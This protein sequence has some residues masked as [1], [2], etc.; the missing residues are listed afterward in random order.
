MQCPGRSCA[1]LTAGLGG[2]SHCRFLLLPLGSSLPSRPSQCVSRVVPPGCPFPSPAGTPLHAVCAFRGLGP[3]ALWVRAACLLPVCA[4][5]L[6]RPTRLLPP[7]GRCGARNTVQG[8]GRA[9]PGGS[10]SSGFPDP[11][12]CSAYLPLGARPPAGRPAFVSW[13]CALWRRHEGARGGGRL[14][15]GF[16]AC[17]VGRS[18]TPDR[19]SWDVRP[20]P[21]IQWLLV[22]GVS[23][24]GPVT[25]PTPRALAN[26]LCVLWGR[27]QGAPGGRL[28]L[29]C[30]APGVA[31]SP[32]PHR[33]C[34]GVRPGPVTH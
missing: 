19:L 7:R 13:L 22:R 14:S 21:A 15:S 28:L 26:W 8:A 29:A 2:R 3:V 12:P 1:A 11:V 9:V 10:C 30:R 20:V 6:P 5:V 17:G 23:A 33:P 4:L 24:W 32:T 25:N 27:H 34:W 16:R 31:S 18:P